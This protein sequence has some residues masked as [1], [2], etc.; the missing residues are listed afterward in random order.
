MKPTVAEV[1]RFLDDYLRIREIPD[2]PRA[3][4]GLQLA[5]DGVV[6]RIIAAVD[7]CRATI[8]ATHARRGDFLL[9]HHGLF[10]GGL[11]RMAGS[12][13]HRIRLLFERGIALYS[14]HIPL[15]CH[16]TVGN[17]VVLARELGLRDLQPFGQFEGIEIGFHG[18]WSA[19]LDSL[20]ERL[21]QVLG[22]AP[23]VI[24]TGPS[25]VQRIGVVTGA[26]SA[27]LGEA[28]RAGLQ[29]LVTGEAPHHAYLDAEELGVSL[30]LAG[31]Y[32]TETFGVRA[33][34][35]VI[36]DQFGLPWEF[37]DHP[38]GM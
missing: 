18:A 30:V 28:A 23:R 2:D 27:S 21:T 4:N 11:Q 1:A 14:A 16:P 29:A 35:P 19:S 34:A 37:V 10:W 36:A 15:D 20:G 9:V 22:T 6:T 24:A 17:N 31:H 38:T 32:A 7:V 12:Y 8:E 3:L 25:A 13:G 26:G 5:R 33:L